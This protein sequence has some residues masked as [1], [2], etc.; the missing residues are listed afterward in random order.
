MD[1]IE[2][3]TALNALDLVRRTIFAVG[4]DFSQQIHHLLSKHLEGVPI[5]S[6]FG[7]A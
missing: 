3:E 5:I 1:F 7:I 4:V 6:P 2:L